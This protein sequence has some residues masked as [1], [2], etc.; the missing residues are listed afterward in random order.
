MHYLAER[1]S[2]EAI[3]SLAS[4]VLGS[5]ISEITQTAAAK[6]RFHGEEPVFPSAQSV[7]M[8]PFSEM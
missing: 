2:D 8:L 5:G 6:A 1:E 3:S 4:L 7:Q